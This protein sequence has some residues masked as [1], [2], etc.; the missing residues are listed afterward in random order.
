MHQDRLEEN[1]IGYLLEALDGKTR[2]QVEAQLHAEPET[3]WRLEQL[4]LAMEPLA[5]D[6]AEVA[7]PPGLAVRTVARIAEYCCRELPRAPAASRPL[8][9]RSWWRRADVVV[10]AVLFLSVL[11]IG[12]PALSRIR[13]RSG[14]AIVEC[15]NNLRVFHIALQT[16]YDQHRKFPSVAAERPRDA[17]GVLVPLLASSGVLPNPGEVRC[18]GNPVAISCGLSLDQVRALSPEDF[19]RK[20][21]TLNPS[22]AYSLGH[23]DTEGNYFGPTLP[24]GRLASEFPLMADAPPPEALTG[25]SKNHGGRGQNVLFADGHVRFVTLR[26]VGFQKDDI[27]LN[28]AQ[29][30]AAGFDPCDSV[31]GYSAA[32]P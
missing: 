14:P 32:R 13:D 31:L 25:N 21:G 28:R 19:F 20:A 10:A 15:Q 22:F 1:L 3:R 18:P 9:P 24:E 16:Y 17:A 30:V 7:P 5:L 4:R 27:F 29:K 2:A 6:R 11:G 12:V 8:A 26:N 23:R